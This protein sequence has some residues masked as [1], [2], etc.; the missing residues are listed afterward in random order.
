M[1]SIT[2]ERNERFVMQ[3]TR[4]V[5][6]LDKKPE[7]SSLLYG[8]FTLDKKDQLLHELAKQYYD[9]TEEYDQIVC[10]GSTSSMS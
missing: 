1:T 4:E 7:F 10:S 8:N 5:E 2:E 6:M 3:Q 9:E